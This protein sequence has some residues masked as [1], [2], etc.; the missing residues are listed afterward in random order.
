M[1]RLLVCTSG[2]IWTA[3]THKQG[4]AVVASSHVGRE[5][6]QKLG[7]VSKPADIFPELKWPLIRGA[8]HAV[9]ASQVASGERPV[10]WLMSSRAYSIVL[11]GG[12]A[13]R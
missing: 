8:H 3:G 12:R 5:W 6:A 10:W 1:R 13:D 7:L 4:L 2:L 9:G 11:F